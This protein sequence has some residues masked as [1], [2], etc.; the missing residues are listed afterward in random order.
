[1]PWWSW[2]LIWTGLILGLLGMLAFFG[3]KLFRGIVGVLGELGSLAGRAEILN[4]AEPVAEELRRPLALLSRYGDVVARWAG[5]QERR[6][7]RRVQRRE[8]RLARAKALVRADATGFSFSRTAESR[9]ATGQGSES[10]REAG[11]RPGR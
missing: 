7:Q 8:Q 10:R 1:M 3:W 9:R 6:G 11:R 5:E 4:A 2:L